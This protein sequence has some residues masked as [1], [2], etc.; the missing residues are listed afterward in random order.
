MQHWQQGIAVPAA[1]A[2]WN[3][4]PGQTQTTVSPTATT[5][6]R[7]QA[8]RNHPN[9]NYSP[10]IEQ[11]TSGQGTNPVIHHHSNSDKSAIIISRLLCGGQGLNAGDPQRLTEV[12]MRNACRYCLS[13]GQPKSETLWHFLHECPLT[14]TVRQSNEA[15]HCW[16]QP[17]NIAKLHRT[18][19]SNKQIRTI[20]NTIKKM[21]QLRRA[22]NAA[23]TGIDSSS[24]HRPQSHRSRQ[25]RNTHR[26]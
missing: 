16:S 9:S 14:A 8:G 21:W 5:I 6:S 11:Q 15:K 13:L 1:K 17:E 10:H 25:Q 20:R 23:L 24:S 12:C 22:F 26:G 19:W 4:N 2:W 18:I 3:E 7:H